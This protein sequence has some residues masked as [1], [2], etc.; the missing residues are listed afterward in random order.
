MNKRSSPI[1]AT[2]VCFSLGAFASNPSN[3][4]IGAATGAVVGAGAGAAA[5]HEIGKKMK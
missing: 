1:A 5:G 2:V 3:S 4:Q